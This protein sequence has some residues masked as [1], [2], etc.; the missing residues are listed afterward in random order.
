MSILYRFLLSPTRLFSFEK[1][2]SARFIFVQVLITSALIMPSHCMD[3]PPI[4]SVTA[5]SYYDLGFAVGSKTC[6]F[7]EA[8][9]Q[10]SLPVWSFLT[11]NT[12]AQDFNAS[13]YA[14]SMA[15]FPELV[16]ELQ[17]IADG[18][19]VAFAR[20]WFLNTLTELE[21]YQSSYSPKAPRGSEGNENGAS[22]HPVGHCTDVFS[23]GFSSDKS[24]WGHNEDS[25]PHDCNLT[26]ITNVTL[27]DA[28]GIRVRERFIAYT[29]AASVAGRAF[30][31]NM[32]GAIISTNALFA[33]NINL[34]NAFAVPRSIHNRALY[35][36]ANPFEA[37]ALVTG[38]PSITSFSL[39]FG[40]WRLPEQ[41]SPVWSAS[42]YQNIEVDP[43]GAFSFTRVFQ[44]PSVRPNWHVP[45]NTTLHHFY[46][47]NN[48]EVLRADAD[49]DTSSTARMRRLREFPVPS[50]SSEVRTML[51]DTAN[52]T[53]PI[54]QHG[55]VAGD[56]TMATAVFRFDLDEVWIY[57]DN[58]KVSNAT[59]VLSR[60]L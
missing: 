6:M 23:A 50:T 17:G 14:A 19:N 30:G 26:Y 28:D 59:I 51:G 38:V 36:S 35:R 41:V 49:P 16:E 42:Q 8:R 54:W 4:I 29:Y 22:R 11:A 34:D 32:H 25:G 7:L 20:V 12:S 10:N 58:P 5:A 2:P 40:H 56:F 27:F 13:M 18:C 48:F 52:A 9:F 3:V 45:F 60:F 57:T 21:S 24:V 46:H 53:W 39:N 37:I 31:W 44:R 1:M 15:I 55:G 47:A 43:T 33:N